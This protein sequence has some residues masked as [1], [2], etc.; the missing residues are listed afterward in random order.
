M[1][2]PSRDLDVSPYVSKDLDLGI[3]CFVFSIVIDQH[4]IVHRMDREQPG[5]SN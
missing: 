2:T 3:N 5:G 1:R 4:F